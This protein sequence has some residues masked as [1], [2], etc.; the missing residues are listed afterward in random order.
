MSLT[1]GFT[2]ALSGLG[3]ASRG[4]QIV[5]DN[6]A[7]A[8]TEAYGVRVLTQASRVLGNSGSG[9]TATGVQRDVDT[10]L[11]ADVREARSHSTGDDV[12]AGFFSRM[13]AAFGTP[14]EPASLSALVDALD[15][16]LLRAVADP[17]S[18]AALMRVAQA[19]SDISNKF[20][21]LNEFLQ[22]QHDSVDHDIS[23]VVVSLNTNLEQIADL[24]KKIQRQVLS[25]GAPAALMDQRQRLVDQVSGMI[26]VREIPRE[27]GRIM[28]IGLDGTILV[29]RRAESFSFTRTPLPGPDASVENGGLSSVMLS[30]RPLSPGSPLLASGHL[31]AVLALR[32]HAIPTLQ[33]DI[34]SLALD[35]AARFMQPGLDPS[36]PPGRYGL[37]AISGAPSIP[38]DHPGAAGRLI[39]NPSVALASGGD[40]WRLRDGMGA[41]MQPVGTQNDNALLDRMRK[42]LQELHPLPG[43]YDGKRSV[44]GHV[45]E[46]VSI[47][48]TTRLDSEISAGESSA[49]LFAL[50]EAMATKGVDTDAELSK[51][52]VLEQAYAA[53]ARV[54]S[55][56]DAMWR[57]LLEI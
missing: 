23:R 6:I 31:G 11:L 57:K 21:S 50:T 20:H 44:S 37:F 41:I 22:T 45:A 16:S 8:Q 40:L 12:R 7:N 49:R 47:V 52:L 5:A 55:S 2:T 28:L 48:A 39:L 15:V 34:D 25:S 38:A 42:A 46:R 56:I 4:T 30:G 29:D 17:A 32:D 14:E 9:V 3:V 33:R 10:V 13:E 24:N 1:I 36:L 26:A 18:T 51:L 43:N 54:L 27:D 19:A 53:N 35:L